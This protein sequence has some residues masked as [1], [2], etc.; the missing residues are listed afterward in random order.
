MKIYKVKLLNYNCH[1]SF[2][3]YVTKIL[4]SILFLWQPFYYCKVY[5]ISRYSSEVNKTK[6]RREVAE[7]MILRIECL[8][9]FDRYLKGFSV[10]GP[11]PPRRSG[12]R[13]E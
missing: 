8:E 11:P 6:A 10:E 12:P 9:T 1:I 13:E 7:R 3:L 4:N 2:Y 5:Y